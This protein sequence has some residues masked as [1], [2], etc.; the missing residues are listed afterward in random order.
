MRF[1]NAWP[2]QRLRVRPIA[3]AKKL[4][5]PRTVAVAVSDRHFGI[6]ADGL[7]LILPS[8]QGDVRMQMF[9]VD[10]SEAQMCGNGVRCLAKYAS[11]TA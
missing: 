6:G 5:D 9:N 4:A 1:T 11:T 8:T 10:G 7:I 2:G 3:S